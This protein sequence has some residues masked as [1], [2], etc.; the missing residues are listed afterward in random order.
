MS[1]ELFVK[2]RILSTVAS[3]L[4]SLLVSGQV[5]QVDTGIYQLEQRA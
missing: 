3:A 5:T 1:N 4:K 2:F